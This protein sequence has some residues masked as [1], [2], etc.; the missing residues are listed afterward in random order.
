M[1]QTFLALSLFLSIVFILWM[2]LLV[3]IQGISL[4]RAKTLT[5]I[6]TLV[7]GVII[8]INYYS[9]EITNG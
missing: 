3:H 8:F 1:S 2:A 9:S 5:L 4:A 6:H 7:L